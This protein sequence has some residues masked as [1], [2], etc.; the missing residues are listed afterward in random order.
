MMDREIIQNKQA[1]IL[2]LRAK[3]LSKIH[4]VNKGQKEASLLLVKFLLSRELYGI[5]T[6]FVKEVLSLKELTLVPGTLAFIMGVI[7]VRG[8]IF[9]VIDPKKFFNLPEHGITEFN[10][11][12]LF[13]YQNIRFGFVTDE[14]LGTETIPLSAINPTP[15]PISGIG[16]EYI[17]GITKEGLIILQGEIL[18]QSKQIQVDQ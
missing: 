13:D 11:V 18:I 17:H 7:N 9:P 1:Q 3:E 14:I 2:H 10:K 15:F 16:A 4:E 8:K 6:R 5:E 12:I